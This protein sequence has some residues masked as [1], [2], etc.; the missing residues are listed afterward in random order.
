M[1]RIV[2]LFIVNAVKDVLRYKSFILLIFL[3]MLVDKFAKKLTPSISAIIEKPDAAKQLEGLGSYLYL[4]FPVQLHSL[5]SD[6]RIFLVL[7]AG[8]FLKALISLWPS[9]DMRRM[10]R[11]ER[12]GFGIISALISLRWIQLV[13]DLVAVTII[14]LVGCLWLGIFYLAGLIFWQQG[15]GQI[16]AV[17]VLLGAFLYWPI[18]IAGFSYSSKIAVIS[19]GK[20]VEKLSLFFLLFKSPKIFCFSWLFYS[21]RIY[22]EVVVIALIPVLVVMYIDIWF[23]RILVI[24]VIA[25]PIYALLKMISFK[26]FLHLFKDGKLVQEEYSAYFKITDH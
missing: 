4:S 14:C 25:C 22:L 21:F 26:V 19:K 11:S 15:G 10:H 7:L 9:S 13:W 16:A 12:K 3:L 1:K 2:Q 8:F 23:A 18:S 20:F 6:Y 5:L 24:S 17:P